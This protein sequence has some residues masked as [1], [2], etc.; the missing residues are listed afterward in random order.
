[1]ELKFRKIQEIIN[2]AK[3]M[4][5]LLLIGLYCLSSGAQSIYFYKGFLFKHPYFESKSLYT[6]QSSIIIEAPEI[7]KKISPRTITYTGSDSNAVG[8][9]ISGDSLYFFTTSLVKDVCYSTLTCNSP[10]YIALGAI[11]IDSSTAIYTVK[12]SSPDIVKLCISSNGGRIYILSINN[13]ETQN[14]SSR[15]SI[16]LSNASGRIISSINGNSSSFK[17]ADSQLWVTGNNGLLRTIK[18]GT[19]MR[20]SVF[21]IA[22]T[23][24]VRCYGNGF[25]GTASGSVF[26]RKGNVFEK[27]LTVSGAIRSITAG[28][29]AGNGVVSARTPLGWVKIIE[30]SSVRYRECLVSA[31]STGA[32]YEIIDEQW[33]IDTIHGTN[34]NSQIFSI[35]PSS[36]M[37]YLST[38]KKYYYDGRKID[39]LKIKLADFERNYQPLSFVLND[40][41]TSKEVGSNNT[42]TKLTNYDPSRECTIGQTSLAD[43]VIQVILTSGRVTISSLMFTGR[44]NDECLK[45]VLRQ[46]TFKNDVLWGY[47]NELTIRSSTNQTLSLVNNSGSVTSFLRAKQAVGRVF[48]IC[49]DRYLSS[50][51]LPSDD[52][53]KEIN[54][55]NLSGKSISSSISGNTI[56]LENTGSGIVTVQVLLKSG[57]VISTRTV[58]TQR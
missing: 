54:V 17:I 53:V 57:K 6:A 48:T 1:M 10:K 30:G 28:G 58:L 56:K 15:D 44:D 46:S 34:S 23:E 4:L 24:N 26:E 13:S 40:G 55:F 12:S 35:T 42:G 29:L 38:S 7:F 2:P 11:G 33:G 14:I 37:D 52:E 51:S 43:S 21:D 22:A 25:A 8:A 18:I 5:L 36:F 39:T 19:S 27:V 3:A 16:V 45:C 47:N 20:D 50:I 9:Y 49:K 31:N 41:A 32:L